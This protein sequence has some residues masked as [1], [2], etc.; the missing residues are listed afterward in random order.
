MGFDKPPRTGGDYPDLKAE[1]ANGPCLL[2]ARVLDFLPEEEGDYPDR[3]RPG[4]K[5]RVWPVLCDIMII[6]GEH[7]GWIYRNWT[8]RYGITNALRGAASSE[9]VPATVPGQHLGIRA[10]RSTRKGDSRETVYG[11]VPSDEELATIERE[12]ARFGGWDGPGVNR[13]RAPATVNGAQPAPAGS[14]GAATAPAT[15]AAAAPSRPAV[16]R[17]SVPA[18]PAQAAGSAPRRPFGQRPA[19][20]TT[21]PASG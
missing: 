8:A 13:D 5:S 9:M 17:P 19:A 6:T 10:E 18:A 4:H 14:P 11:N 7:A 15:A 21:G 1:T 12:F 16:G 2:A 20:A 3:N